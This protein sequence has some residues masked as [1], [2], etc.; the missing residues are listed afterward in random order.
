MKQGMGEWRAQDLLGLE[1]HQLHIFL[2]ERRSRIHTAALFVLFGSDD[3]GRNRKDL[4]CLS[5]P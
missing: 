4:K 1:H 3:H 5:V 2:A